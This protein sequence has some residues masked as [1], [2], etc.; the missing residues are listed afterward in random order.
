[1]SLEMNSIIMAATAFSLSVGMVPGELHSPLC[2]WE[3][4]VNQKFHR[5]EGAE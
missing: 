3:E 4:A 2:L 1:M 5:V